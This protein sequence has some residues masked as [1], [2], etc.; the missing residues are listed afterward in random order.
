MKSEAPLSTLV[1]AER[2]LPIKSLAGGV[3]VGTAVVAFVVHG[4]HAPEPQYLGTPPEHIESNVSS[5]AA[6]SIANP[7]FR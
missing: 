7:Y 5:I 2:P 6:V 4:I 1:P 3:V